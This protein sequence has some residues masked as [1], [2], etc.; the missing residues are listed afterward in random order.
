MIGADSVD[1]VVVQRVAPGSEER[2]QETSRLAKVSTGNLQDPRV[3]DCLDSK[4]R[5]RDCY[6]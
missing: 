3:K 6:G 5:Q 4:D 2:S 1:L